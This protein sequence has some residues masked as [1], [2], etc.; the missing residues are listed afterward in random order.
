MEIDIRAVR[1]LRESADARAAIE[2]MVEALCR[3][4]VDLTTVRAVCDWIQY[5]SNFRETAMV[6]PVLATDAAG[7]AAAGLAA[8]GLAGTGLPALG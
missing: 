5:R 3:Y 6:R 2:P 4:E 7:L 8:A 1:R